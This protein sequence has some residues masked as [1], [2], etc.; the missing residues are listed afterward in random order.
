MLKEIN[1]NLFGIYLCL[2]LVVILGVLPCVNAETNGAEVKIVDKEL[3]DGSLM[4]G[5]IREALEVYYQMNY[6]RAEEL[7]NDVINKWP[8][9]PLPYLVKAGY[10]LERF[11]FH[12]DNTEDENSRFKEMVFNLNKKT[13]ALAGK[14]LSAN[15]DDPDANYYLGAG[16]G[17]MGRFYAINRQWWRAFWNG[18]KG[19]KLCEKVVNVR[20]DYYDAYLGLGIFHYL[21]ATLPQV[22]KILSFLLGAPDGDKDKGIREIKIVV[23]NSTLLSVEARRILFRMYYEE[24]DW[25]NFHLI[26]KWLSERYPENTKF[27]IYHIYGLTKTN[28]F[29]EALTL[30]N[31]VDLLIENDPAMFPLSTR[32]LYYR[33]SGHLNFNTGEYRRAIQLYLEALKLH[34]KDRFFEEEWAEDFF[35][36]ASSYSYLSQESMAFKYLKQAVKR[37]WNKEGVEDH[38]AWKQY[39]NNPIF[40]RIV[41]S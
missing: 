31:H 29:E 26:I 6:K 15:P 35:S 41:G 28:H 13:V 23:E 7:F 1:F 34:K 10:A 36:L 9:H 38:P 14:L 16:H 40:I 5:E 20:P 37:G 3:A 22:V 18:K 8:D 30:L 19:F 33:Y 24:K 12:D 27:N 32:T 4:N 39:K 2:S 21:T 25:A 11:R 17:N